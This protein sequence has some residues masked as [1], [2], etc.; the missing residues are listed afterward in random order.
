MKELITWTLYDVRPV[1]DAP[2]R[3]IFFSR[4]RDERTLA[5][6]NV[7]LN[8]IPRGQEFFIR[9]VEISISRQLAK[10]SAMRL[11]IASHDYLIIN[12]EMARGK[13]YPFDLP[14]VILPEVNFGVELL[15]APT[16]TLFKPDRARIMLHGHLCRVDASRGPDEQA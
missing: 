16:E 4:P 1:L 11:M 7:G 6:T 9:S 3:H 8:G 15:V 13:R 10:L 14:I 5:D 12:A 2:S